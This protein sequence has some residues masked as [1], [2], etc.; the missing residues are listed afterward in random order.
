MEGSMSRFYPSCGEELG[1]HDRYCVKCGSK[2]KAPTQSPPE[3]IKRTKFLMTLS[4]K[5]ERHGFFKQKKIRNSSGTTAC[6]RSSKVRESPNIRS[7]VL[8]NVGLFDSNDEET[9]FQKAEY[10]SRF[11]NN[12]LQKSFWKQHWRNIQIMTNFFCS[13]DDYVLCYPDQKIVEFIS[14][15]TE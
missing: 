2:M 13:L 12:I 4:K 5:K 1:E 8:I 9:Y 14:S 7:E 11:G 10:L 6:P 3:N 15:T